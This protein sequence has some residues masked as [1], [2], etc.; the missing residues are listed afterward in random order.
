MSFFVR[1][2]DRSSGWN[3][4]KYVR[5]KAVVENT[6]HLNEVGWWDPAQMHCG[7]SQSD[8]KRRIDGF[9][10]DVSSRLP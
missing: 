6:D 4:D 3:E 5:V 9:Y 1:V 8:L 2:P 7:E 10:L